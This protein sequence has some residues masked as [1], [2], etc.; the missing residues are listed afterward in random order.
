MSKRATSSAASSGSSKNDAKTK[1]L[2][3]DMQFLFDKWRPTGPPSSS[4]QPESVDQ[5]IREVTALYVPLNEL[6]EVIH[7]TRCFN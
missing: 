3:G 4:P 2:I 7:R 5:L 6:I 1:K